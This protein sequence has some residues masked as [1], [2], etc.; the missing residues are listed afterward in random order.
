M[1]NK[2]AKSKASET[3]TKPGFAADP[4]KPVFN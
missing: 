1:E 3:T 2:T 4:K